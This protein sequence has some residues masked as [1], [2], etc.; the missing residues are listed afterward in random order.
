VSFADFPPR[1]L[2]VAHRLLGSVEVV[3]RRSALDDLELWR[4]QW[5][6]AYAARPE[7][8]WPW[9]EHI[10]RALATPGLFLCLSLARGG[11]LDALMSLSYEAGASRLKAGGDRVYV[12]YLGVAPPHRQP[13]L[14]SREISG[15]GKALAGT[16]APAVS[17]ETA[18][19]GTVGLHSKDDAVPLYQ[20][21]DMLELGREETDDG[22]WLYFEGGPE[23]AARRL[24]LLTHPPGG[25]G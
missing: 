18:A 19:F 1:V 12:E 16:V 5:Q 24:N 10:A 20:A 6:A 17:M 7:G 3:L 9:E 2:T 11:A 14:G 21:I 23:W 8:T 22:T 15:L 13:P 4:R 25:P